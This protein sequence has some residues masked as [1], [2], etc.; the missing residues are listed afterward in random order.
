MEIELWG[1]R[2][3]LENNEIYNYRKI[4]HT[5]EKMDWCKIIFSLSNVGY[6]CCSLTNNKIKRL[7]SF[8]RLMYYFYNQEWDILNP[9][10]VI[11]HIDRNILNN[12]IENL[13]PLT[14]Q[15]NAFNTAAKG[16][17][18]DKRAKKW[19]ACIKLNGK[20]IYLG[21]YKTEQEAHEKYLE[22]K[23]IYHIIIQNIV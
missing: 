8:H 10:L 16:C 11:D 21:Y 13:R 23:K 2:L 17:W 7:F 22:A 18:F 1:N 20:N 6:L 12:N 9:E 19:R 5:S 15:E 14:K 3:K 4:H